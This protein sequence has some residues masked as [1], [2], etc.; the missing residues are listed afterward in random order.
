[1]RIALSIFNLLWLPLAMGQ[2]PSRQAFLLINSEYQSV[3]PLSVNDAGLNELKA[4]LVAAKFAVREERNLTQDKLTKDLDRLLLAATTG[5]GRVKQNRKEQEMETFHDDSGLME[6][7]LKLQW[8]P[9]KDLL[10][11]VFVS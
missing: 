5:T 2:S 1:M 8:Y 4:A 11:M 7:F 3:R 9:R 6:L 10:P